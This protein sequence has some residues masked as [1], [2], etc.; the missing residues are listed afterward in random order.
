MSGAPTTIPAA[1]AE[2]SAPAAGTETPR[3]RAMSG[4]SPDSMNSDVPCANTATPSR[5]RAN[6]MKKLR[7]PKSK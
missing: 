2:V 6:G 7:N 4:T 3:S 1:K 5:K